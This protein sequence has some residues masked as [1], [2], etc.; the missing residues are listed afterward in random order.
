MNCKWCKSTCV[1]AGLQKSGKQK[2]KC[3]VCG[4]YQQESY[5]YLSYTP[6]VWEQFRK[7][8]NMGCGS[9]QMARFLEISVNTVQKWIGKALKLQ[10]VVRFPNGGVYDID[11]L[12]TCLG[13]RKNKIWV[14]YG[15]HM[16]LRL[17]VGL[18]VGRR[19]TEGLSSVVLEVLKQ[20]PK[21]VNTDNHAPYQNL[22]DGSIHRKGRRK[23][24]HIERQHRSMRKDISCLIRE[25]MCYAKKK[26]ILEARIRWYFWRETDPY[27]FLKS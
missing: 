4:K 20:E 9:H 14:C 10:P 3:K 13:K 7:F 6:E 15:W 17:P 1:K 5:V 8:N 24:N 26:E 25:T 21:R 22:I 27:F 11:E 19:N 12:Q 2:Y 16:Q 23:A 18:H